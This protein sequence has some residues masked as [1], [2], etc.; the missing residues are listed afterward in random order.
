[1]FFKID[2]GATGSYVR[3]QDK[4]V[5]NTLHCHNG[6]NVMLPDMSSIH[7]S[8]RGYLPLPGLSKASR[9]ADVF[10]DLKSASLLSVGK[11]C[12]DNCV[13]Q[14][15]K[16]NM[17]VFKNQHKILEG[18]RNPSDGLWDVEMPQ[19]ITTPSTSK[20]N[21]I[22]KKDIKTRELIQY[23]QA[24]C[25]NPRK[26]TFIKAIKNGNFLKWPGLTV[27]AVEKY[28][29]PT[30]ASAKGHLNQERKF[31]QSTKARPLDQEHD[32][33]PVNDSLESPTN[34]CMAIL[35]PFEAK[36][37][38]YD[39]LTGHFPYI[40]SQ[41]NKYILV[42][43][44]Y[45]SNA[46]LAEPIQSRQAAH[47]KKAYNKIITFLASRGA[48][49]KVFILDNEVSGELK[50]A[51]QSHNI[52]YQLVPPHMHRRNAAERAIQTFKHHFIAGLATTDPAFPMSEWDCLLEQGRLSLNLLRNARLNKTLSSQ[53]FLHGFFDLNKTP[54]APPGT[55][56]IVHEKPAQ[57][58]SWG[59]H[60][61]LGWYIGPASEHY[62][63]VRIYVPSTFRERI[64]DTVEFFPH[65]TPF[66]S[67]TDADHLVEATD[68]ILSILA[69]PTPLLPFLQTNSNM[70][71]AIAST[72]VLLNRAIQRPPSLQRAI[73]SIPSP[74][75][76]HPP[77]PVPLPRVHCDASPTYA[78]RVPKHIP[79]SFSAPALYPGTN[80]KLL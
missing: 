34:E 72:A 14:F 39:D 33:F 25:F 68:T 77:K 30:M 36:N 5:L 49:P 62:R 19:P 15:K 37:V 52:T 56:V 21:V 70:R 60:G 4:Q 29:V 55:K 74:P 2:S 67:A 28:F 45:D 7:S 8:E 6:P 3:E 53:A 11:L 38:G 26:T 66:P 17:T 20:L 78:P 35:L 69:R 1:M 64:S 18:V 23:Y 59:P 71:S 32:Y 63:C 80:F 50:L 42:I 9:T 76:H 10:P 41:G 73:E 47:I 12:D 27:A 40:S 44:D 57:R 48:K 58:T 51:I 31:L 24:C 46:I 61:V 22:L 65:S 54:L 79:K 16:H 75:M 13:V 43:Y